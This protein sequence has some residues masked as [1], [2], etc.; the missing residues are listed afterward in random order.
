VRIQG[1]KLDEHKGSLNDIYEK[2]CKSIDG[3]SNSPVVHT[4]PMINEL[5]ADLES[6]LNIRKHFI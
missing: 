3:H 2:C 6:F 4:T 1:E 5:K